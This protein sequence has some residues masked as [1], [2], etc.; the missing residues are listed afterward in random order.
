MLSLLYVS[1]SLLRW[2]D[3]ERQLA[4]IV[5]VAVGRNLANGVT[6]ALIH[7]GRNFAQLLEG[8]PAAVEEIMGSIL[9][10][11]RHAAVNIVSREPT[12]ERAFP[13]WSMLLVERNAHTQAQVDQILA[14]ESEDSLRAGVA[15]LVGWMRQAVTA[16]LG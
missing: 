9:V 12:Q 16:R 2:S 11:P 8:P 7:T 6:G 13:N 15:G 14:A 4:E 5:A 10:D 3:T 1:R